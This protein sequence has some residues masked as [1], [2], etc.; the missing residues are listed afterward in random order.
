MRIVTDG[1]ELR[2]HIRVMTKQSVGRCRLL[3]VMVA[4]SLL[5]MSILG[6]ILQKV[7]SGWI[8]MIKFSAR[9]SPR[10]PLVSECPPLSHLMDDSNDSILRSI[11]ILTWC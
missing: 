2:G 8:C 11:I 9:H 7:E 6:V 10:L 5:T 4:S 1:D 3:K